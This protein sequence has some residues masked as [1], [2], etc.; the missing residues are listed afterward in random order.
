MRCLRHE[1]CSEC[2]K[3]NEG[4]ELDS[5]NKVTDIDTLLGLSETSSLSTSTETEADCFDELKLLYLKY[6][7]NVKISYMNISSI[8][9]KFSGFS[10]MIGENVNVLV[11]AE[12]KINSPFPTSQFLLDGF[13][14]PYRLDVSG[15]SGEVWF[16]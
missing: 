9:N 1:N 2:T 14:S 11:I 16:M 13:K 8:T 3:K 7:R 5:I 15:N 4:I 10:E 6:P 12:T